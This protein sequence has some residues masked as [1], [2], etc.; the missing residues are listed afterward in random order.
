WDVGNMIAPLQHHL[1]K[2]LAIE[3]PWV[4]YLGDYPENDHL[5]R[6]YGYTLSGMG[7]PVPYPGEWHSIAGLTTIK[8]ELA[9]GY[10][11]DAIDAWLDPTPIRGKGLSQ[12]Q[13]R[14]DQY[15]Y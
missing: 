13:S 3:L 10:E 14:V 8:G 9:H 4:S 6:V 5:C 12:A 7:F 15:A 2:R 1:R 11:V